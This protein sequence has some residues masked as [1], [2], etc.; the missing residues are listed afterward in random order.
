MSYVQTWPLAR[1]DPIYWTRQRA[2]KVVSLFPAEVADRFINS[3]NL[4]NLLALVSGIPATEDWFI[5]WKGLF[6]RLPPPCLNE[7]EIQVI[8][9]RHSILGWTAANV[10][11][12]FTLDEADLRQLRATYHSCDDDTHRHATIRW[13]VVH[14]LGAFDTEQNAKLLSSALNKDTYH[15]TRYGAARSLVEIAAK[16]K[17]DS[18]CTFVIEELK[19]CMKQLPPRILEEVGRAAFYDSAQTCWP[20]KI[21]PLLETALETQQAEADRERWRE[22][23][24]ELKEFFGTG[25][26]DP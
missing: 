8:T 20:G 12:R 26:N 6:L 19:K 22:T 17:D 2:K 13:R 24:D 5:K 18:L 4:A 1:P 25:G 10:I 23:V 15:W 21:T 7:E 11:K 3:G 9:N 16:T 14:A